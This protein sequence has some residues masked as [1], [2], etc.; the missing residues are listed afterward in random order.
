[1]KLI[2]NKDLDYINDNVNLKIIEIDS[3][4]FLNDDLSYFVYKYQIPLIKFTDTGEIFNIKDFKSRLSSSLSEVIIIIDENDLELLFSTS[5]GGGSQDFNGLASG[6]SGTGMNSWNVS[7]C[8][9]FIG[10]FQSA[11]AFNQNI[12]NWIMSSANQMTS[13][14][15]GASNFNQPIGNW[16]RI[17]STLGNATLMGSMLQSATAFNQNISNWNVQ[18]VTT[19]TSMF[20]NATAFNQNIGSWNISNV[21]NFTNFMS[22]KSNL[23]YSAANLDAIYNGWSTRPVKTPITITFG[24]AKYTAG[25]SAGRAILTGQG[26]T[27]TDGGI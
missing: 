16:E 10:T 26:W 8:V 11:V 23:N 1:M 2:I 7:T 22:G 6:V 13:M 4:D 9:N 5:G 15:F 18:N 27:I 12:N 24:T 20:A 21:T 3:T 17:G 19:M 25:A 14:F